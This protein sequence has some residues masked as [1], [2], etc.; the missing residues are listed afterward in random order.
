MSEVAF[1]KGEDFSGIATHDG[2][3]IVATLEGNADYAALD[4]LEQMLTRV[5]AEAM[6]LHVAEA[7]VDL[8]KLEFMNSSCFKSFVSWVTEIQELDEGKRYHIKFLSNPNLHWQKRSLH[9]LRCFA[10]ELI[11]VLES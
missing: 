1:V 9:S 2:N 10:V 7:I 11:T 6:R 5:H 3:T 8:R 4:V